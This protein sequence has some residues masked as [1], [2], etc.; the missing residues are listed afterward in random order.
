MALQIS[1]WACAGAASRGTASDAARTRS[2]A[3]ARRERA[4]LQEPGELPDGQ[5]QCRHGK[6]K[7]ESGFAGG[8]GAKKP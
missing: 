3:A 1:V 4:P 6:A 8:G 7:E 2:S 5:G